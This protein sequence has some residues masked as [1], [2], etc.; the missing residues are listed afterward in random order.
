MI[1]NMEN[2]IR[3]KMSDHI[4]ATGNVSIRDKVMSVIHNKG[5]KLRVIES[6]ARNIL[7]NAFVISNYNVTS[8]VTGFNNHERLMR[9]F[10]IDTLNDETIEELLIKESQES[11]SNAAVLILGD[12]EKYSGANSLKSFQLYFWY[13]DHF[14]KEI[15][16]LSYRKVIDKKMFEIALMS[17]LYEILKQ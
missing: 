9:K 12:E 5:I 13:Q 7:S 11:N 2:E 14:V 10:E 1:M 4:Y 16:D 17:K 15:V 8:E 6:Q 3:E